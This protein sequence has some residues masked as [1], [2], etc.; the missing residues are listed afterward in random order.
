MY[1]RLGWGRATPGCSAACSSSCWRSASPP[2]P[3][4]R[5]RRSRPTRGWAPA[6]PTRSSR[7]RSGSRSAAASA[8]RSTCRRRWPWPCTCSASARAGSGSSP[9]HP[10][11]LVD[12]VIFAVVFAI[13]YVSADLAFRDPVRGHGGDRRLAGADLRQPGGLETTSEVHAVGTFPGSPESDFGG[14]TSG[15]CSRSSSRR[16]PASWRA[17]TCPANCG[18]RAEHPAS[19]R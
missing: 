6:A 5:C 1:L 8:C 16:R 3:A 7:G 19:A 11:L 18:T 2:P 10:P 13:A 4:C 15:P 14:T 9:T 12:L 17:P